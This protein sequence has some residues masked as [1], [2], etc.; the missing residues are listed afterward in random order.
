MFDK[1]LFK[2]K[3]AL[4]KFVWKKELG[5]KDVGASFGL[6]FDNSI[7]ALFRECVLIDLSRCCKSYVHL[8]RRI[9]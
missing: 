4:P 1:V 8:E 5:V 7:D 9:T 2:F 3:L 6:I